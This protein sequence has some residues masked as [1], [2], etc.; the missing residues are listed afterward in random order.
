MTGDRDLLIPPRNSKLLAESIPGAQL[1]ILDGYAHRVIWETTG[2]CVELIGDFLQ[3]Q[4]NSAHR[5][6]SHAG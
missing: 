4:G 2:R 3:R 1:V 5:T 6:H